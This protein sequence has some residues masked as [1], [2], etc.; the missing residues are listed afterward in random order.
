MGYPGENRNWEQRNGYGKRYGNGNKHQQRKAHGGTITQTQTHHTTPKGRAPYENITSR[1]MG[2]EQGNGDGNGEDKDDKNRKKYR[3]TKYDFEEEN[4]EESDTEDSFEFEITPQQLSQVTPGGGVLKLTLTK[5]GPLKI[6]TEAQKKPDP[7]QTTVKTVYDP[8]KEKEPLQ[9]SKSIRDKTT[10]RERENFESQRIKPKEVPNGKREEG[11]PKDGGPARQVKPGGNGGADENG[12]LDKGRK[13]PR[14]GEGPPNG[15]RKINGGGG[16]S[17]PSDDDGDGDGS[18]PPSSENTPPVRRRHR[19]PK[20]VYVLQGPPG[21]PGQVGQPGQ[22]GR[23]GRD[24]Q[25]PQLTKAFED[26]LKTQKTGWDTTNLENSFDYFGRTMHEVL[27]AQQKT[28]Q[29]LEEQF[30]RANETQEFQTEVMQ[31]MANAN[32]QM[33]F[34]HMFPSVPMYDGSNPDMFDD[35]LYQIESLCE[36]S[37]RDIRIELMGRASAQVKHIIRSIPVDIEWEVAHRELKSCLTEEKSRA[38]SAFK[39][40]QIKQKPNENLRIFIL[41][42]QDL[43]ASAIGKQLQRIQIPLI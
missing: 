9:G 1:R 22:A 24:G 3:D 36:I 14:K 10:Y 35:W 7:T 28:T 21:P 25:T 33:K 32:F 40:A 6:T 20:F 42:Y 17:D 29:N 26:A 11:F 37:H 23:D 43:H 13:P 16:G 27:K 19:R 12:G 5:K 34:D 41:R 39:L 8:T 38:H 18:T 4:E 30:K 15:L 2:G 31:D